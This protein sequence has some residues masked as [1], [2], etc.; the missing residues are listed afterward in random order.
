MPTNRSTFSSIKTASSYKRLVIGFV[1][2]VGLMLALIIYF[3]FSRT[4]ITLT[5]APQPLETTVSVAVVSSDTLPT[6]SSPGVSGYLVSTELSDTSDV[7][8]EGDGE[9]IPAP[10]EGTVTIYNNWSQVQPLAATTRLLSPDGVLFR[11]K[12]RVDV[13]AGGKLEN[14]PV[15]ADEAGPQ[16]DIAPTTFTIPGLWEGLQDQIYAES[17]TAMTGGLRKVTTLTQQAVANARDDVITDL[18]EEAIAAMR[19]DET[20]VERGDTIDPEAV[21]PVI[22]STTSDPAVGEETGTFTLTVEVRFYAVIYDH[23]AL[24]RQAQTALDSTI[25]VDYELSG[26]TPTM[27]LSVASYDAEEDTARLEVTTTGT[28]A[29]RLTHQIFNREPLTNK[30]AQQIR[31]YYSNFD[32]VSEAAVHFAPFWVTK[33]PSLVDHIEIKVAQ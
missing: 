12:D 1:I 9:E 32:E 4:T 17:D 21:V 28:I 7:V 16:G 19:G 3:S 33:S 11:I 30:D 6:L 18:T 10:A 26:E 2:G 29:P 24:A 20:V 22:L 14:V 25:P 31:T 15:Y 13:P 27:S 8:I 5:L 23:E